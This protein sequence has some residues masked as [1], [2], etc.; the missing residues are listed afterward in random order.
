MVIM[1]ITF[2]TQKLVKNIELMKAQYTD[3]MKQADE[4]FL[5]NSL[6]SLADGARKSGEATGLRMAWTML[7]HDFELTYNDFNPV[8][9]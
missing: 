7:E 1:A 4:C 8:Q 5:T 9:L 2:K 6:Q 3:L